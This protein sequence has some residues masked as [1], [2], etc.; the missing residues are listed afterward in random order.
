MKSLVDAGAHPVFN[1]DAHLHKVPIESKDMD[2]PPQWDGNIW[3][4]MEFF[5]TRVMPH[6]RDHLRTTGGIG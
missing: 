3:G 1:S 2:Y 5:A 4:F 6:G